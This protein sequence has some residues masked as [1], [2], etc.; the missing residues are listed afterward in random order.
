MS[1]DEVALVDVCEVGRGS[2]PR[3]INDIAYFEGG[4]IPWIKI[5]DATVSG[6]YIYKTK[7]YVNSYGASFSRHLPPNS[8]ILA[9][10]GVSL[11]QVKFLGIEG[12]I[13]DGWLY[14]KDYNGIDKEFLY[15]KLISLQDYFHGNSYGA[16]IQNINTDILRRTKVN[17]PSLQTQKRIADILSAYDNLIEN[18]LKR[19]KLLE[20]AA[21]NI[22]KEWFVNMRFPDYENTPINPQTNLPEGWRYGMIS[23]YG[24]VITG[25]T[26]S[27][28]KDE[29]YGSE[30]PF[31]KTPDM[32]SSPYV[33]ETSISLSS[34]GAESQKNKFLP[35]DSV[36]VS[37]IGTAGVVALVSKPSQTNQQINSVKFDKIYKSFY[38]YCFVKSLKS[39]LEALGSNGATMVNVN[40][41][42]FEG[43]EILI[44]TD[45]ILIFFDSVVN[46]NFNQIINILNQNQ[47]LKAGRD[48]LL[49]RLM[50]QT[51]EV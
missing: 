38:F 29:Y 30:I 40:K 33:I 17:L 47:K 15:Y 36:M 26:P 2:S 25:K 11:G 22:Y 28:K 19:I 16:A 37:C 7:E 8:L 50:N 35:K 23:E 10:S 46:A 5:A 20:Q 39:Q 1:W 27:T 45:D 24:T 41:G 12:C 18:N 14:L 9:T 34:L 49:P 32:H 51:I 43:I 21:Q 31:V 6:K 13:H 42:K 44:P 3:P 48:I 4:D